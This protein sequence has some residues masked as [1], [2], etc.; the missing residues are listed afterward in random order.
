M[1]KKRSKKQPGPRTRNVGIFEVRVGDLLEQ[2]SNHRTH[3]EEQHDTFDEI[4]GRLGWYGYPDVYFDKRA[5]KY[6][7][8]DGAL[9]REHLVAK[10]GSDATIEVNETDFSPKE[11]KAAQATKDAV[12]AMS[13]VD[14][15]A[16]DKLLGDI[17]SQGD[18]VDRMLASMQRDATVEPKDEES[19]KPVSLV[20][21][22]IQLRPQREY[23]VVMCDNAEEWAAVREALDLGEVRRGGY[24]AGS[25]Y[26]TTGTQRV[27]KAAD[28]LER[29]K[30]GGS[31]ARRSTK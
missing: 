7:L 10:Y 27:V 24:K 11:A 18:H 22:A 13:H 4:V 8:V 9:R 21:Q 14:G 20:D 1:A 29:L 31:R 23:A 6:R 30:K 3:T 17:G 12:A 19:E 28:L 2:T 15:D 16:F 26:D 5:K 25:P